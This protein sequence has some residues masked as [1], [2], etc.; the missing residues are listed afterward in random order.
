MPEP[1]AQATKRAAPP[2][3]ALDPA[4]AKIIA[5]SEANAEYDD[6]IKGRVAVIEQHNDELQRLLLEGGG[7]PEAATQAGMALTSTGG[8]VT[9]YNRYDGREVRVNYDQLAARLKV[10]FEP[11]HPTMAGQRVYT[12]ERVEPR[13]K[14]TMLCPL[15]V[16]HP[17]RS[18][19]DEYG[20]A[21]CKKHNLVSQYQVDRHVKLKHPTMHDIREKERAEADRAQQMSFFQA[22][23]EALK[24]LAEAR[25]MGAAREPDR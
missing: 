2:I 17:D 15:H 22:Q 4:L 13:I 16:D 24:T 5:E 18:H 3:E 19:W 23:A 8:T 10:R 21:P 11:G 9:V 25:I 12:R 6:L 7:G 14:G 20:L 1:K